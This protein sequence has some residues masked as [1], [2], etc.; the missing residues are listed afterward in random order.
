MTTSVVFYSGNLRTE[1]QHL[2]SGDTITT[3]APLDNEGTGEAFSPTDLAATSLA[4]CMMTVMGIIANR[5][6]IDI[7]GTRADVDKF[8]GVDPR[9]IV[10]IK[11]DFY[12]PTGYDA[13]AKKLLEQAALNCPVANSLSES[14]S[15]NIHF[16]YG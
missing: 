6:N 7:E 9:R 5:H 3:D 14:I 8:M 15:Q 16:N 10:E 1:S 4:N 2:Q 13:A 12:F 11:I